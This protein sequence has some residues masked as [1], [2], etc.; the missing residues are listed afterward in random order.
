[1]HLCNRVHIHIAFFVT[2]TKIDVRMAQTY[3]KVCICLLLSLYCV[4][5]L[6]LSVKEACKQD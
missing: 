5:F 1:M 6:C 3:I 4:G 2:T